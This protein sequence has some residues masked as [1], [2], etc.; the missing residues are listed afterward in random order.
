MSYEVE[1][2]LEEKWENLPAKKGKKARCI[3]R[4]LM[5]FVGYGPE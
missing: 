2:I 4:Y 5:Q 3:K 1:R